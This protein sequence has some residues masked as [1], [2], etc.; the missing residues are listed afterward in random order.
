MTFIQLTR[1]PYH[2]EPADSDR[3]F[4]LRASLIECVRASDDKTGSS[5][6]TTSDDEP[7]VVVETPD[8]VLALLTGDK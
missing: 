3:S 4:W 1:K 7:Y 6:F 8:A 2:L 5:V